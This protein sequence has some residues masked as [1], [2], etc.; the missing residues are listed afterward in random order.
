MHIGEVGEEM[1]ELG[2][3]ISGTSVALLVAF[4]DSSLARIWCFFSENSF[5]VKKSAREC[6]RDIERLDSHEY[7]NTHRE[8]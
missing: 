3:C 5:F 6:L 4:E 2:D 8:S 7:L 1:Y